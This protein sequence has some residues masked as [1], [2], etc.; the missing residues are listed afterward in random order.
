MVRSRVLMFWTLFFPIILGTLFQLAFGSIYERTEQLNNIP[1]AIVNEVDNPYFQELINGLSS[2]SEG[3]LSVYADYTLEEAEDLLEKGEVEGIYRVGDEIS[4]VVKEN[5]MEETVLSVLLEYYIRTEAAITNVIEEEPEKLP[6]VIQ[7][8]SQE[9]NSCVEINRVSGNMDQNVQYFYAA[10]A[11]SCLYAGFGGIFRSVF[12]CADL[13]PVGKRRGV[14][15]GSKLR[16]AF[17]EFFATLL[18][19]TIVE[20]IFWFYLQVILGIEIGTKVLP[21]LLLLMSGSACGIGLGMCI[22]VITGIKIDTKIGIGVGVFMVLSTL[23]GL[24]SADIKPL[25]DTYC[26]ILNKLNPAALMVDGFTALNLHR[27]TTFKNST[28]VA[29]STFLGH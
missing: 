13:S 18:V 10:F 16:I 2:E 25:I 26:P 9:A 15:P 7:A 27:F 14:A 6:A 5:G 28:L 23:S 4:L 22:G 11:M 24:M 19:Q 20:V 1:V 29:E 8:V 17:A 21:I 3:M 12:T